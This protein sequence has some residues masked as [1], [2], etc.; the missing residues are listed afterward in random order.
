MLMQLP[1]AVACLPLQRLLRPLRHPLLLPSA[2]PPLLFQASTSL[3]L[4]AAVRALSIS[5]S[6]LLLKVTLLLPCPPLSLSDL[7]LIL[8]PVWPPLPS[9]VALLLR[10]AAAVTGLSTSPP[11]GWTGLDF[12]ALVRLRAAAGRGLPAALGEEVGEAGQRDVGRRH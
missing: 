10:V 12:V 8:P 6:L 3:L 1:T 4:A 5:P 9:R 2:Q 7:Q 11:L